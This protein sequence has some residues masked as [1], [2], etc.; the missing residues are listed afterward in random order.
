VNQS[1][2]PQHVKGNKM[3]AYKLKKSEVRYLRTSGEEKRA[4]KI[5]N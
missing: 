4:R 2:F 1:L 3:V 5:E